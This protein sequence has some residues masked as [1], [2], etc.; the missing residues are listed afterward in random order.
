[1]ILT[2]T[3]RAR[4]NGRERFIQIFC[5]HHTDDVC[6]IRDL[7][8]ACVVGSLR[9]LLAKCSSWSR[10]NTTTTK[11]T[12]SGLRTQCVVYSSLRVR[13]AEQRHK[14]WS[15]NA[16]LGRHVVHRHRDWLSTIMRTLRRALWC[17]GFAVTLRRVQMCACAPR[18]SGGLCAICATIN[19]GIIA[20][21][22]AI[23][24]D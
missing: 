5:A 8:V 1:M 23:M 21:D 11:N 24:G 9:V 12:C 2:P 17:T 6:S 7:S 3:L 13:L 22:H 16:P 18:V 14:I 19:T 4:E 20:G 10:T 15:T